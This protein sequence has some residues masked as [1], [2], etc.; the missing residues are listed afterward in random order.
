MDIA[1]IPQAGFPIRF[2]SLLLYEEDFVIAARQCHPFL[3]DQ[4]L[5]TYCAAQHLVVSHLGDTHGFVDNLLASHGCSRRVALTVPNFMLALA[6]LAETD[7]ISALPRRFV[8]MHAARFGVVSVNPPL[9]LGRFAINATAPKAAIRDE[10]VAWLV[11]L[12]Q[13]SMDN[14]IDKTGAHSGSPPARRKAGT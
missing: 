14:A 4:T 7:F 5:A 3:I 10:G 9:P 1:I 6:V 8:E 2:A 12:L 13:A 11:R